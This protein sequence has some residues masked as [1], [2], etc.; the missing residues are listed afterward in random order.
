MLHH[1]SKLFYKS[2]VA[3]R[4][5]VIELPQKLL[6]HYNDTDRYTLHSRHCFNVDDIILQAFK[7]VSTTNI[8]TAEFVFVPFFHG[9]YMHYKAMSYSQLVSLVKELEIFVKTSLM[10]VNSTA[11]IIFILTHDSG[12]CI[13]FV[14][15]HLSLVLSSIN[16][17]ISSLRSTYLLQMN[18]DY[19]TNCYYSNKDIVIPSFSC[20]TSSLVTSFRD[21]HSVK[22]ILQRRVFA[23]FKGTIWGTGLATR[24]RVSCSNLWK[25]TW[26]RTTYG[27]TLI[28]TYYE[29]TNYLTT[30]NETK[31]C[32]IIPGTTGWSARF[33]DAIY[34]GC[35]PVLITSST[36]HPF[37]DIIN[38]ETFS[39][40]ISENQL[41]F[42]E[43]KLLSYNDNDLIIKQKYLLRIRSIFVY[44]N[45]RNPSE[46]L[47]HN[48]DNPLFFILLSLRMKT[49]HRI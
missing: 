35:I 13:G 6:P 41:D 34:A 33:I 1:H 24:A 14:W 43:E 26:N 23:F 15:D 29:N 27:I 17:R 32:L 4:I 7:L 30:L 36:R 45:Y 38:Y 28:Q 46:I 18:G 12:G 19:N 49:N 5:H 9:F 16:N 20:T 22:H 25:H 8:S 39:I 31:F 2:F 37:E 10:A 40:H 11:K 42:L 47:L 48:Q 21:I 44:E 3:P